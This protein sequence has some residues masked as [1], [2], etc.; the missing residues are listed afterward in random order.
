MQGRLH[1]F[2][3]KAADRANRTVGTASVFNESEEFRKHQ[4]SL[5]AINYCLSYSVVELI[6]CLFTF[7][8]FINSAI[9]II[10]GAALSN[11]QAS[12][13]ANLFSIHDLLSTSLAPVTGTLFALAL[14]FSGT[15]TGIVCTMAGQMVSEGGLNWK[16]SP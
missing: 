9:L 6:V 12:Q 8:L 1:D 7:A 16:L 13:S 15:S 4:P 14:L 2:N 5:T 10:A 11:N 3:K